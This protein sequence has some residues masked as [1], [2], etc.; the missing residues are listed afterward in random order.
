M[1]HLHITVYIALTIIQIIIVYEYYRKFYNE[2][3]LATLFSFLHSSI[4]NND[5]NEILRGFESVLKGLCT[6]NSW[7]LYRLLYNNTLYD[8]RNKVNLLPKEMQCIKRFIDL[9]NIDVKFF[10]GSSCC[11]KKC[12]NVM[13]VSS[14]DEKSWILSLFDYRTNINLYDR[15]NHEMFLLILLSS[16]ATLIEKIEL[17]EEI[18]NQSKLEPLTNLLHKKAFYE[19]F[20]DELYGIK[21]RNR[22]SVL[23]FIDI[24]D[25]K[26]INDINGHLFGDKI[27]CEV[28]RV[29]KENVRPYDIIG[30]FGGDEFVIFCP[31]F[32]GDPEMFSRRIQEVLCSNLNIYVSI[33][34][35]VFPEDGLS[36]EELI[37]IADSRMYNHKRLLKN[38]KML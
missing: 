20:Q 31:S 34:W 27:L 6:F 22:R 15:K 28:A 23:Y 29:L 10:V 3:K 8:Y 4:E 1:V 35:A 26:L 17:R 2:Q 30:R 14:D 25:F 21:S 38:T 18:I 9:K 33:G 16:V 37:K 36:F 24:N 11:E 5:L 32:E 12:K 19:K 7:E 13:L